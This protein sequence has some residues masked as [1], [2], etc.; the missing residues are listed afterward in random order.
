[1][2]AYGTLTEAFHEVVDPE[3]SIHNNE[4]PWKDISFQIDEILED[5]MGCFPSSSPECSA[6]THCTCQS[7]QSDFCCPWLALD[8]HVVSASGDPH[9]T[10]MSGEKFDLY[11]LGWSTFIQV[12]QGPSQEKP[13]LLV[14]G[15]VRE[16]SGSTCAPAYIDEVTISGSW[17]EGRVV[18]VKAG[19]L[20]SS[21]Q[22][23]VAIDDGPQLRI[24]NSSDT[25]FMEN[26]D[27]RVVGGITNKDPEL[28][29]PDAGVIIKIGTKEIEVTQHTEGRFE[30]SQ[31]MLDISMAG[32][33]EI[34]EPVGGWLGLDGGAD[35]GEPPAGCEP[36][37]P[38][39]RTLR[40]LSRAA[41]LSKASFSSSV[42]RAVPVCPV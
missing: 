41:R 32:L 35:A 42:A 29:G 30:D 17:A 1:M 31:S 33:D 14:R 15:H 3:D 39:F 9:I 19:P 8:K 12:P 16:Y 34:L 18:H 4:A 40:S 24:E 28:W 11:R 20:E 22:F 10:S 25:T 36:H 6:D 13:K 21:H 23:S 38:T 2:K 5:V 26:G 37:M 7:V 27:F